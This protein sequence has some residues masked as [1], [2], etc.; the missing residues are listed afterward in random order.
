MFS[1]LTYHTGSA[2]APDFTEVTENV[3]YVERED[4][5][6]SIPIGL[7]NQERMQAEDEKV[8][9]LTIGDDSTAMHHAGD[10]D[11]DM[12]GMKQSRA[13]E[14]SFTLPMLYDIEDSETDDQELIRLGVGTMRK[15][16]VNEGKDYED[17]GESMSTAGR[18][19]DG[20]HASSGNGK[21]GRRK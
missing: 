14:A 18:V 20:M 19:T 1:L 3:E 6:D 11:H 13:E 21:R 9:V 4:E 5:F 8:D 10:L 12:D 7:R 16:D 2:L 17:E 15:K